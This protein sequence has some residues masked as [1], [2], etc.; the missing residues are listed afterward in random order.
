ME[1]GLVLDPFNPLVRLWSG[2]R[3]I[4][5]RQY[6]ESIEE[7][8]EAQRIEPG[9][10]GIYINLASA[11]FLDGNYELGIEMVKKFFPGDEELTL[12]LTRE[13]GE[14]SFGPALVR[15]AETLTGRPGMRESLP[16][17][18]TYLYAW[19]GEREPTLDWLEVMYETR[20]PVLV[21]TMIAPELDF[22]LGDPRYQDVFQRMEFPAGTKVD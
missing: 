6:P 13:N 18:I 22:V 19:A 2:F 8:E 4:Y 11:Y 20:N 1:R 16:F 3:H 15:G 7:F 14:S 9:N 17:L 21:G 5:E 12:A 10:P